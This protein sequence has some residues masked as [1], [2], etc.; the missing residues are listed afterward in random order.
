MS[1]GGSAQ[2]RS[3]R[4]EVTNTDFCQ[5][6]VSSQ[7]FALVATLIHQLPPERCILLFNQQCP[8]LPREIL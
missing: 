6:Q 4:L 1:E 2:I 3:R 8:L 5:F 7:L